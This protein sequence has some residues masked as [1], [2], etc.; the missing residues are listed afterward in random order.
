MLFAVQYGVKE[1]SERP[2]E[3]PMHRYTDRV[4]KR[5]ERKR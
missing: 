2:D 5:E 3:G 4:V 1:I